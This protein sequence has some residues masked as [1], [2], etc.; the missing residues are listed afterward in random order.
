MRLWQADRAV[1]RKSCSPA[2]SALEDLSLPINASEPDVEPD[3]N[4][5]KRH[6]S[7]YR[8]AW[9]WRAEGA[10]VAVVCFRSLLLRVS[11]LPPPPPPRLVLRCTRMYTFL[12]FFSAG[13]KLVS[14]LL[15]NTKKGRP[16]IKTEEEAIRVCK[17]LLRHE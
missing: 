11:V 7:T 2:L 14:F 1:Y 17:A 16:A 13:E 4:K 12:N 3:A 5:N 8:C 9:G 10:V 6:N 15:N